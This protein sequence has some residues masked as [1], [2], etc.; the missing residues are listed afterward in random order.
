MRSL[1]RL[2]QLFAL[3]LLP[4]VAGMAQVTIDT[5]DVQTQFKV[6]TTIT[7]HYDSTTTS[8]NIGNAGPN[9]WDFSSFRSDSSQAL[10]SVT[11]ASTP[12]GAQ[13][14]GSTHAL[15]AS[16]KYQGID[17]TVYYYFTLTTMGL[18]Q[19]GLM[20]E[21]TAGGSGTT[22]KDTYSPADTWSVFPSTINTSWTSS[23]ADTQFI[24]LFG[25]PQAP[26][27]VSHNIAYLI[28]GYGSMKLPDGK[29]YDAL[30]IQKQDRRS[31]GTIAGY[32]WLAKHGVSVQIGTVDTLPPLSGTV[33]VNTVQWNGPV[34]S[35]AVTAGRNTPEQYALEQNYPN[36]FNP[37]TVISYQLPV[38][39]GVKL[40]VYDVLGCEVAV[41][42]NETEMPGSH[43]VKFDAI[44]LSSGV[45]FYRL[46]AGDF[47][48]TKRLL[49]LR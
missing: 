17:A 6:G 15:K 13:F 35:T 22:L 14:P 3:V 36:P 16:L 8:V 10:L 28:D 12:F 48:E 21:P 5:S 30:R 4:L 44:G 34:T 37:T 33:A 1:N 18:W 32:I 19:N 26:T 23:Y 42:V 45:Y 43:E 11:V 38:A 40:A 39:G 27:V 49:L 7:F 46:K 41:L 9:S 47:V 24:T 31:N 29:T 25:I 20:G 2:T